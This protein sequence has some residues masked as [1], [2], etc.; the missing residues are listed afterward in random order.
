ML[1]I[2]FR[3]NLTLTAHKHYYKNMIY[4]KAQNL[5]KRI[6]NTDQRIT[7]D[8]EVFSK[9]VSNLFVDFVAPL[10]DVILYSVAMSKLIGRG[11]PVSLFVYIII[12]FGILSFVTPNFTRVSTLLQ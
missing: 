11:G 1:A 12:A 2:S 10:I 7:Q 4:Y 9:Q 6:G 8:I 5:D 3:K